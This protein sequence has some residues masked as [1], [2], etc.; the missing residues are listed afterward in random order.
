ML[1]PELIM[2]AW[3]IEERGIFKFGFRFGGKLFKKSLKTK[4]KAKAEDKLGVVNRN[5][6]YLEEGVLTLPEDADLP[7]FLMTGGKRKEAKITLTDKLTLKKLFDLYEAALP[8]GAK[9]K[10]TVGTEKVHK[11]HFLRTLGE[12]CR[13]PLSLDELQTHVNKRL[14]EP[15]RKGNRVGPGTIR[16]ELGTL[17][18]IWEWGKRS[19]LL[20]TEFP[21]AGLLFPKSQDKP[22]FHTRKQIEQKLA[23]GGLSKAEVG[24]LWASLYLELSEIEEIL[25]HVK[26]NAREPWVYPMMAFVART[27]ARRSEAIRSHIDDFDFESRMVR[28]R[29]KKRERGKITYRHVPMSPALIETMKAWLA[30]HPGGQRTFCEKLDE[31]LDESM[32]NHHFGWAMEASDWKGKLVGWHVFRH[33]FA[34]NC[35]R[36]RVDQRMIDKWMGHQTEAMRKRYQHLFPDDQHEQLALV[37]G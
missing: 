3:L 17:H 16:K 36:K 12:N 27:G 24:E 18:V 37:S 4:N 5:L 25:D 6:E 9:E 31:P 8:E 15:G 28:I 35:V 29:E 32:T 30:V 14:K 19:G 33:S 34:S 26:R 7:T 21:D 1:L 11:K 22:P 20:K 13:L 10:N 23:R 2:A